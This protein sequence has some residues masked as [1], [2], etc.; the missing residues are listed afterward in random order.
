MKRFFHSVASLA[1]GAVAM[2]YLDPAMGHR[3]RAVLRDKLRSGQRNAAR[4]ARSQAKRA[5]DKAR[6]AIREMSAVVNGHAPVT[7]EQLA[8]R[9]RSQ[10]GRLSTRPG[11][12][13]VSA[14]AGHVCLHGHV[15]AAEHTPLVQ[16]ISAM[17][18]VQDV[19]DQ[20]LVQDRP[21]NIPELPG[22]EHRPL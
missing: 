9:V 22:E 15:L 8:E 1:A 21:G 17:N 20:L 12:I 13:H 6:G 14:Q 5:A 11:A 3:R 2:Y 16:T 10:L 18:G 4:V 19:D 7:D